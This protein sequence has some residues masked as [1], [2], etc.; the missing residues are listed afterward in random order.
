MSRGDSGLSRLEGGIGGRGPGEQKLEVD[1]RRVRERIGR[2]EHSLASERKRRERRRARRTERDVPVISLVGYTNAGKSTLLNLLTASDV[3]VESRMFATLDPT[4]RRLRLPREREVV[5]N[6]TVGFIRDLPP[7]LLAAFRATLEEIEDSD[8]VVHLVDALHAGRDGQVRAVET[9]LAE[10]GCED[11]PRLMVFN[12][13]DKL[14]ARDLADVLAA[15]PG[16]LAISALDGRGVPELLARI[17][18]ALAAAA[19]RPAVG[20]MRP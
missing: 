10:L 12:K 4:S 11:L 2:L 5:I 15:S 13:V 1:R 19:C 18:A 8:L 17:D 14:E 3:L 9:I 16:A 7:D 6:D 20:G